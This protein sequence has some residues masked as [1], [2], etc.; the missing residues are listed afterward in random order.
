MFIVEEKLLG[1]Y[2]LDPFV[3]VGTEGMWGLV[4]YFFLLTPMQ[5]LTC[6]Y[7]GGTL[8]G[9]CNFGY[10]E[11]S[12][13]AFEQ[14]SDRHLIWY[15]NACIMLSIA[16]FNA[17]G[18]ATT[19]YA[20]AAQRSTIDTSRTVIIWI[21]SCLFLG[22]TFQPWAIPGF[23]MLVFGTL[24]YNE[25]IVIPYLGYDMYTVAAIM[26][27]NKKEGIEDEQR[28]AYMSLSPGAAYDSTRNERF[29]KRANEEDIDINLKAQHESTMFGTTDDNN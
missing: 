29:D 8:G 18:I 3:V 10:L 9:M 4:Y 15:Q 23:I 14:M 2:C 16:C 11:N 26:A 1:D 20:S 13:Y 24:M 28:I 5:I 25:I 22:E 21:M 12:A 7:G 27:R 6:G 17:F 19:K